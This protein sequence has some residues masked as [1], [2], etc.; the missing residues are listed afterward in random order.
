MSSFLNHIPT[1]RRIPAALWR[2]L[3]PFFSR[4]LWTRV[5]FVA[6]S[7]LT[8]ATVFYTVERW[9]W[10]AA[11]E[12]YA[13]QARKQGVKLEIADF[14]RPSVVDAQN[15]GRIPFFDG[16]YQKPEV[17]DGL[18]G[19]VFDA[20]LT[21][22]GWARGQ[23]VSPPEAGRA[24]IAIPAMQ[25]FLNDAKQADSPNVAVIEWTPET[26]KALLALLD[27]ECGDVSRQL[28][29]AADRPLSK[30]PADGYDDDNRTP[31]RPP[32]IRFRKAAQLEAIRLNLHA[33]ARDG[34]AALNDLRICLRLVDATK[35]E[36]YFVAAGM[37]AALA[38]LT[39]EGIW[40]GLSEGVWDDD[41]LTRIDLW[42][43]GI[44][45]IES[46]QFGCETERAGMNKIYQGFAWDSIKGLYGDEESW[47]NR[48]AIRFF[49]N[50]WLYRN[51]IKVNQYFDIA[52]S[53]ADL[54]RHTLSCDLESEQRQIG[55]AQKVQDFLF[56]LTAPGYFRMAARVAA[57]EALVRQARAACALE[58]FRLKHGAYPEKLDE[59][60]AAKLLAELPRDPI[61]NE[62][63]D[64]QRT[65]D[66][67]Y[68]LKSVE[69]VRVTSKFAPWPESWIPSY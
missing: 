41:Q 24:A 1:F 3:R 4:R 42:L 65:N 39:M 28:R 17:P 47:G 14:P 38:A 53:K 57:S 48:M 31:K 54:S 49:P 10:R 59:L 5:A 60:I 55:A 35:S 21:S 64:F 69:T 43:G 32:W 19:P 30:F 46:Y 34:D 66:G 36:P 56:L 16:Y 33:A 61:N 67:R 9:R 50:G 11:W 20:V 58:R 8:L 25:R 2:L 51:Q 37:R 52:V 63:M 12:D 15:F 6:A 13:A 68:T 22:F 23:N 40:T 44:D 62:P 26:A 18:S 27:K 45:L 29:K 7:L